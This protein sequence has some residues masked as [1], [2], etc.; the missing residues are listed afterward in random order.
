M[1]EASFRVEMPDSAVMRRITDVFV[2][3]ECKDVRITIT[4][5]QGMR[6]SAVD[7]LGLLFADIRVPRQHFTTFLLRSFDQAKDAE[8]RELKFDFQVPAEALKKIAACGAGKQNRQGLGILVLSGETVD[9]QEK[10]KSG[11]YLPRALGMKF[12][13]TSDSAAMFEFQ[14]PVAEVDQEDINLVLRPEDMAASVIL[15]AREFRA[16]MCDAKEYGKYCSLQVPPQHPNANVRM[17]VDGEDVMVT[18]TVSLAS[19]DV[20]IILGTDDVLPSYSVMLLA[21]TSFAAMY[22]S[23]VKMEMFPPKFAR[24]SL[25]LD[26]AAGTKLE[27]TAARMRK[28]AKVMGSKASVPIPLTALAPG[29]E[30][31][32]EGEAPAPAPAAEEEPSGKPPADLVPA[33]SDVT[34]TFIVG[35]V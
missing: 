28:K 12:V 6:I 34:I 22:A 35:T 8:A 3:V 26:F 1:A 21:R 10:G 5:E 13:S 20:S 4:H 17:C 30:G 15:R 32:D 11:D 2:D 9:G 16:L 27:E 23:Y 19:K 31:E 25:V 33:D 7:Q 18:S 14:C 29:G 24:I